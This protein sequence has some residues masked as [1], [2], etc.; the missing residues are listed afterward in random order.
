MFTNIG[1]EGVLGLFGDN[2]GTVIRW[3][4]ICLKAKNIIMSKL[5]MI[6]L[7]NINSVLN[8]KMICYPQ[9][10]GFQLETKLEGQNNSFF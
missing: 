8:S 10:Q 9:M 2:T 3:E 6:N 1:T 5:I 4:E 7:F